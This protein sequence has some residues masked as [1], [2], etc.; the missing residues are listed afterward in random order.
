M[1]VLAVRHPGLREKVD[2]MFAEFWATRDVK[3]MIQT[4]YGERLSRSSVERYKRKHWQAR[5]ELVEQVSQ[6]LEDREIGRSGDR[7]NRRGPILQVTDEDL[8]MLASA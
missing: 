6:A 4:Q 1:Q 2:A 3:R 5:R 7:V 8:K